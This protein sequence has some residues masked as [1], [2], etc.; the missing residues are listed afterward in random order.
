VL[1]RFTADNLLT[2]FPRDRR[3][4]HSKRDSTPLTESRPC[5]SVVIVSYN[6]ADVLAACLDELQTTGGSSVAEVIVVDNASSDGTDV[7][8]STRFPTVRVIANA[9]NVGFGRAC[10]Q[11]VASAASEFVLLLNSDAMLHPGALDALRNALNNG[12]DVALVG[13]RLVNANGNSQ[14]SAFRFPTP[15]VLLLE[16][17]GWGP[18]VGWSSA[19][20]PGPE[21]AD[22]RAVDWLKGAVLLARRQTLLSFGPFDPSFFMY[23]EEIDLCLRLRAADLQVHYV[24]T[25]VATHLGGQSTRREQERMVV[26]FFVS[27]YRLCDKHFGRAGLSRAVLVVRGVAVLKQ[28]RAVGRLVCARTA[29]ERVRC[30]RE[31]RVWLRVFALSPASPAQVRQGG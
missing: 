16:Q 11:G 15:G 4:S 23:C 6:T 5:V 31:L 19:R 3:D 28:L 26:E 13:P 10:N 17:L 18:L 30:W 24:T 7:M 20:C 1:T 14:R 29:D 21:S 27:T 12:T 8:L 2:P 9:T 25:A 22:A